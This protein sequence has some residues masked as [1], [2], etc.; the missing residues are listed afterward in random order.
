MFETTCSIHTHIPLGHVSTTFA[1]QACDST[2]KQ[3]VHGFGF[4]PCLTTD[5][6][7]KGRTDCHFS[8]STK[9]TQQHSTG[10]HFREHAPECRLVMHGMTLQPHNTH[11]TDITHHHLRLRK[12]KRKFMDPVH[13]SKAVEGHLQLVLDIFWGTLEKTPF[14]VDAKKIDAKLERTL[15][16]LKDTL[17]NRN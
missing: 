3:F 9:D 10:Q 15:V 14:S 5:A 2:F 12:A 4:T 16:A 1:A 17:W 6:A 7:R 11:R 8:C 13:R